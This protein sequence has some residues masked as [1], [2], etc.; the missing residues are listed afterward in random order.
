MAAF[1]FW[2][3]QTVEPEMEPV[4][5]PRATAGSKPQIEKD[6]ETAREPRSRG[7]KTS[8]RAPFLTGLRA[9]HTVLTS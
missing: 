5:S 2:L 6:V 7:G 8:V 4:M 1:V 9:W 3:A